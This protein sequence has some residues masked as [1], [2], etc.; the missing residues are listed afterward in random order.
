MKQIPSYAVD[1]AEGLADFQAGMRA[2]HNDLA[3]GGPSTNTLFGHSAGSTI[4]GAAVLNGNHL[5]VDNFVAVGPLGPGSVVCMLSEHARAN[6]W[7]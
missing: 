4:S 3:T 7:R 1:G 2:S 6:R 5:D